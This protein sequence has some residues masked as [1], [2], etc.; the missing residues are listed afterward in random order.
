MSCSFQY[1]DYAVWQREYLTG[2]ILEG[3]IGYWKQRLA[4]AATLELPTDHP[5]PPAPTHR[6]GRERIELGREVS[7]GLKRLSQREG[8][9]LFMAL[10]TAFKV[11]LMRY[12]GQE[13]LS[14][15][16]VIANR[17]RKEVEGLIGFFVNTLVMR[18][19]LYGNPSFRELIGREREVALGAYARQE[20]PYEKLVEEINPDRDLSRSPLFQVFMALQNAKRGESEIRGLKVS[21]IGEEMG[22][23]KFDLELTLTEEGEGI[24]GFLGYS[25]DLY[26]GE[27]IGRMAR[28]YERVLTE[29]VRDAEQNI[30]EIELMSEEEKRQLLGGW[31]RA[32]VNY[33]RDRPIHQL[34]EEQVERS[35]EAVALAY[36]EEQISYRELNR[37]ANRLGRCLQKTGPRAGD[38]RTDGL[39]RLKHEFEESAYRQLKAVLEPAK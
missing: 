13:D 23:A 22:V 35:L 28:H 25:Q 1:A 39:E 34:F 38:A 8:A 21:G 15:G 12:S 27:T 7:E 30:C 17:T 10:M 32:K 29:V 5:R 18:T 16:T 9:T 14:V 2:E 6:G 37:R 3:E 11:V 20:V 33:D 4:E 36:G 24:R 31:E 26:E 19:D